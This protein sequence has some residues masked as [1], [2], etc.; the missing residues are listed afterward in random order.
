MKILQVYKDIHPEVRGG[1]ERYIH[2]L[3]A[4]LVSAGHSVNV[5]TAGNN[6]NDSTEYNLNDIHI[7]KIPCFCRLFSNPLMV[8]LRDALAD[9][10]AD[11][12]HF[13]LPLPTA[14]L[15]QLQTDM[16][17]P[18]I[19]TY[20][21]DIVRQEWAMPV[22]GPF[23]KR[24]LSAA[25]AV[26]ATSPRYI[27]TSRWLSGLNN[28]CA[29]PIG[30]DLKRFTPAS[31]DV[32]RDYFLFVGRFRG[33]KGIEVLLD[34]W[35]NLPDTHL[36]MVGGGP[37]ESLIR[38]RI[39]SENLNISI[40]CDVTDKELIEYY[41]NATA[42]IL[43]STMRSEAFGMVQVEAMACGTP[44][45]STNLQTGVPWVNADGISGIVIT[46][47]NTDEIISA[48]KR[49]ND[50]EIRSALAKGAFIRSREMFDSHARFAEVEQLIYR[51][52][53][54]AGK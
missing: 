26:M 35:C 52:V 27:E 4:Y 14:V 34:A 2:D 49:M 31:D 9:S 19:V 50:P 5:I 40:A 16:D 48:V 3:S 23:L 37:M 47:D 21:S 53:D 36:I 7:R 1:I 8:G 43:P 33:Y 18:Y 20:H 13:H 46:Q 32:T 6:I 45:I 51:V 24:F 39:M 30:A 29:V 44:V 42:L 10:D 12:L 15:A 41:R 38:K 22:Y 25:D 28:V 54:D 17:R 11:I